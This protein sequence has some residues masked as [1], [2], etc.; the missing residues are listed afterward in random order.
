MAILA[1]AVHHPKRRRPGLADVVTVARMRYRHLGR[2]DLRVS[3]VGLGCNNFGRT[4]GPEQTRSVID[5]ALELGITLFDTSNTYG[6]RGG[7][8]NQLGQV[9]AGRRGEIVLATKWGMDMGEGVGV[10]RGS[11]SYLRQAVED[12]LRRLRTD[13]IDLY[14]MHVPDPLTPIGETLNA[15]DELV[16][17][18]KVRYIGS[19][20]FA[21]WQVADADWIARTTGTERFISTQNHLSL[22]ERSAEKELLPACNAFGV[23]VLP[24]FPLAN[25]LL[26]GKYRRGESPETGRMV[27]RPIGDETFDVLESLERFA[28]QRDRT[29]LELAFAWLH[30]QPS[31][32]S[33]IAGASSAE[34]VRANAG[35]ADWELDDADR[36]EISVLLA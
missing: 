16:R 6:N 14:Q 13:Y 15:L 29:L 1:E 8:E 12:S 17:E 18:G 3:A 20:N 5:A 36:I 27:D 35:A 32:G 25:G 4:L 31:V 26:T 23:G 7:S 24:F 34:Q 10:A 19:S 2:S 28:A 21:A 33:V 11:R 30:S 9:L 22:L